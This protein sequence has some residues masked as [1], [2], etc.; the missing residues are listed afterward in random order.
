MRGFGEYIKFRN[1]AFIDKSRWL[2]QW[3]ALMDN[4]KQWGMDTIRLAGRFPGRGSYADVIQYSDALAVC[5]LAQEKGYEV[6]LDFCHNWQ[7]HN[8]YFGSYEWRQDW[9]NMMNREWPA[10][11]TYI[12]PFNEPFQ[13]TWHSSVGNIDGVQRTM[14]ELY[15]SLEASG[16]LW[17]R[18]MVMPCH[19]IYRNWGW[20]YNPDHLRTNMVHGFHAWFSEW[21]A[22]EYPNP[23]D[24]AYRIV[25]KAQEQPIPV[26]CDETGL[27]GTAGSAEKQAIFLKAII[28]NCETYGWPWVIWTL[29]WEWTSPEYM[30]R[31]TALFNEVLGAA[32]PPPPPPPPPEEP[33]EDIF[34]TYHS[35]FVAPDGT[36]VVIEYHSEL[37]LYRFKAPN[38][39]HYENASINALRNLITQQWDQ[40][41][42]PDEE[43]VPLPPVPPPVIPPPLDGVTLGELFKNPVISLGAAAFIVTVVW[44]GQE[45]KEG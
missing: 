16:G 28:Q 36:F 10:N 1:N 30:G 34:W 39:Q 41:Q 32:P 43:P 2:E 26:I 18:R 7:D 17:N 44:L 15:D 33:P 21:A 35:T 11:V 8:G 19:D 23:E 40:L 9:A 22:G 3:G 42:P 25:Y 29:S 37:G 13:N 31:Y 20:T 45:S 12:Q 6:M 4:G 14:A 5:N 27:Y 38:G 24:W